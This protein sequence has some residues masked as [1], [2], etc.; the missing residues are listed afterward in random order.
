MYSIAKGY[1]FGMIAWQARLA[2]QT[3]QS[4]GATASRGL[5]IKH[6]CTKKSH[7]KL[8]GLWQWELTDSNGF[9]RRADTI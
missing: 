6:G 1:W 8:S 3:L 5:Y 4:N 2:K 9:S 7:S